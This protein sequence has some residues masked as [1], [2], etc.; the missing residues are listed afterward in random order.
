MTCKI[1]LSQVPPHN[2]L[3]TSSL[4]PE[5]SYS[6]YQKY[7]SFSRHCLFCTYTPVSKCLC[8]PC[9]VSCP[10][11]YR[12]RGRSYIHW[13]RESQVESSH[14]SRVYIEKRCALFAFRLWSAWHRKQLECSPTVDTCWHSN[15]NSTN[16]NCNLGAMSHSVAIRQRGGRGGVTST[17]TTSEIDQS[18]NTLTDP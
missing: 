2:N 10:V 13:S 4:M 6:F 14:T 7:Y 8:W 9:D 12:M 1:S 16:N 5:P 11:R 17:M 3:I 15:S 18:N